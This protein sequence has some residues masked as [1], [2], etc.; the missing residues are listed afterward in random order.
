MAPLPS[1]DLSSLSINTNMLKN[2]GGAIG[3]NVYGAVVAFEESSDLRRDRIFPFVGTGIVST[4]PSSPTLLDAT[5][6]KK[7]PRPIAGTQTSTMTYFTADQ[8]TATQ[9]D[10]T[11]CPSH[12]CFETHPSAKRH[13][14]FQMTVSSATTF[15]TTVGATQSSEYTATHQVVLYTPT[16]AAQATLFVPTTHVKVTHTAP[17]ATKFNDPRFSDPRFFPHYS[18]PTYIT[19]SQHY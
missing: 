18:H 16:P 13:S 2:D 19:P 12:P 9:S 11:I 6:S 15:N 14:A 1:P 17:I 4:L 10:L 5:P 8:A 3:M 7:D